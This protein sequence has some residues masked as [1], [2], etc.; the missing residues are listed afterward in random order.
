[1]VFLGIAMI[2]RQKLKV[3][4]HAEAQ[5]IAD[6]IDENDKNI[7]ELITE[8]ESTGEEVFEDREWEIVDDEN[9]WVKGPSIGS[10]QIQID[11][12]RQIKW[13]EIDDE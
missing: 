8:I 6:H 11:R 9:I 1:M 4:I 7:Y 3:E 13:V 2:P 10:R 5:I 12:E